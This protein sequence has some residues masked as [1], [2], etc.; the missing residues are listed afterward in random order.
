[1]NGARERD[2]TTKNVYMTVS[3]LK[4][5]VRETKFTSEGFLTKANFECLVSE[6]ILLLEIQLFINS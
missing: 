2:E 5:L 1:M 3:D 6:L 4:Q